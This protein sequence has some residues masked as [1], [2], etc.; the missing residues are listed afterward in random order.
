[1]HV[2]QTEKFFQ[3]FKRKDIVFTVISDMYVK[4]FET[5]LVLWDWYSKWES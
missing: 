2:N 1:M 5:N 3:V 4:L